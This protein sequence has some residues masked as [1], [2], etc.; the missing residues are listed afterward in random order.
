[1][2][3]TNSRTAFH[4]QMAKVKPTKVTATSGTVISLARNG[5]GLAENTFHYFGDLNPSQL[6]K[7][8]L[9]QNQT[10]ESLLKDGDEIF[11]Y[12]VPVASGFYSGMFSLRDYG[13]THLHRMGWKLSATVVSATFNE[14]HQFLSLE[15]EDDGVSYFTYLTASETSIYGWRRDEIDCLLS[16][17]TPGRT[18]EALATNADRDSVDGI[19][20]YSML[21]E[22]DDGY[23]LVGTGDYPCCMTLPE[24]TKSFILVERNAPDYVCICGMPSEHIDVLRQAT[25]LNGL[26]QQAAC[27][28]CKAMQLGSARAY[29]PS[30]ADIEARRP[31]GDTPWY[32][33]EFN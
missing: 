7:L 6:S 26:E 29:G 27:W 16:L 24:R 10:V 22:A 9:Y 18:L 33:V 8:H 4:L 32:L 21:V 5:V 17:L 23:V 28:N 3:T 13:K 31:D 2:S 15:I 25:H 1:M 30:K 19:H 20:I 11:A 14:E 12:T